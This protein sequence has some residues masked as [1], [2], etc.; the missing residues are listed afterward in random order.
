MGASRLM[1]GREGCIYHP[2]QAMAVGLWRRTAPMTGAAFVRLICLTALLA[3]LAACASHSPSPTYVRPDRTYY[4]SRAT[5]I[6]PGL[7]PPP[8]PGTPM[9]SQELRILK[10]W[11]ENRTPAQCAQA[12]AES[13]GD[14]REL[15]ADHSPFPTDPPAT[16]SEFFRRVLNDLDYTVGA[17]KDRYQRPRP[18][19]RGVGLTPCINK[20]GGYSYPSGHAVNARV[21]A[22]ILADLA[23][24]RREEFLTRSDRAALNRVISGVHYPSDITAGKLVGEELYQEFRKSCVFRSDLE[25]LRKYVRPA[26]GQ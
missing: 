23:P 20:I 12:R 16:V 26:A 3:C 25:S 2:E 6:I 21:F 5:I 13:R 7:P 8:L 19:L 17:L 24:T 14:Y 9:D 22:L 11:Q 4:L 10:Q 15:F 18:F 1:N